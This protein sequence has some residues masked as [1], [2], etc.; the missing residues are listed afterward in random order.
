[1]SAA[2]DAALQNAGYALMTD[3]PVETLVRVFTTFRDEHRAEV[4]REAADKVIAIR[5]ALI[6]E[7]EMT[8]QYLS[9]LERAA[10]ELRRAAAPVG[11]GG[12]VR[13]AHGAWTPGGTDEPAGPAESD[14]FQPG[15]TYSDDE[16]GW[17]FRVDRITTHPQDGKR[18]AL[19]WRFF[20]GEWE[21]Y[22]YDEDDWEIH[23]LVG[24]TD[25]TESGEAR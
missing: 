1:M 10:R 18:T 9:G 8:G 7:P 25:V 22:A 15:H 16:N 23:R 24:H 12:T 20:K 17:K 14:F 6:T 11:Q 19:G 13:Y 5:D 3:T 2:F 4:L 21:P